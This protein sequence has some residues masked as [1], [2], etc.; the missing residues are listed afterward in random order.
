M[1]SIK[2]IKQFVKN[3]ANAE[4]VSVEYFY[5]EYDKSST[6]RSYI[7]SNHQ[8]NLV[9]Q[10]KKNHQFE[11]PIGDY[12]FAQRQRDTLFIRFDL[13]FVNHE[14]VSDSITIDLESGEGFYHHYDGR[15]GENT[16]IALGKLNKGELKPLVAFYNKHYLD[17]YAEGF[18]D[19]R[20]MRMKN[21]DAGEDH[22]FLGIHND[23]LRLAQNIYNP[24]LSINKPAK[25]EF[26]K[27]VVVT[28]GAD[29]F[30][31]DKRLRFV[32][33]QHVDGENETIVFA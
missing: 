19:E 25:S 32:K 26:D 22:T 15:T 10:N 23:F 2:T 33:T 27:F 12:W 18:T 8:G 20:W 21:F 28:A 9:Y 1:K 29:D 7:Q 3:A 6:G 30:E 14:D 11:S 17:R 4:V 24:V 5:G 16:N 13:S 31:F